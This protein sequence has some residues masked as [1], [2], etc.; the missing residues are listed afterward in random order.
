MHRHALG[1]PVRPAEADAW[2]GHHAAALLA[3][4]LPALVAFNLPPSATFLNQ[5]VALVGW[6]VWLAL[7]ATHGLLG[8]WRIG[9]GLASL[10]A[11]L[12]LVG[13]AA[14]VSW[15]QHLPGPLA[16]SAIG[17]IVA[18]AGIA[19]VAAMLARAEIADRLFRAFCVA[20]VVGGLLSVLI[21]V[22]QMFFPQLTVGGLISATS[23]E[24][25][26]VGNLRQ[27]NHLSS[28]LLW[29]LIA[30]V[31]LGERGTLPRAAVMAIVAVLVFG[32][33]MSASRTGV[34][35]I[36]LLVLWGLIDRRLSRTARWTLVLSPLLYWLF[37]WGL[38]Q[39]AQETRQV[40]GGAGRFNADGDISSSRF[41]IWRDTLDLVAMQPLW[42]V[43]FGEFN[44]AW[45]LTPFPQ[46]P[47]AFFDHTHNLPLQLLVEL[48][49]PLAGLVL[50]ALLYAL[51]RGFVAAWRAP[52]PERGLV[53]A[54]LLMV[55][56]VAVHS[57]FEYPLWYAYF[58]L[59]TAFLF[60]LCLGADRRAGAAPDGAARPIARWPVQLAAALLLVGG[61]AAIAD[62]RRVAAI[63]ESD[64]AMPLAERIERGKRSWFFAH[65]A[66]YAAATIAEHPSSEMPSFAVATH[67]LLDTRLMIA[68]A[69]ALNEA[70]D[71]E[72][73][74]H[75]AQRLRE[76]RNAD[77]RTFFAPCD[78]PRADAEPLPFQ[79]T[80]PTRAFGYRDFLR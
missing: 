1:A 52:D 37:W 77:A 43:G 63:F 41:A 75:L 12:G 7:I 24:G 30:A 34:A 19:G 55:M 70:G 18:A 16:A 47:V 50:L 3:V 68:W 8:P 58:L 38:G 35:G 6:G 2:P 49:W 33:V 17:L 13:G 79:C 67:Y 73:A 78:E 61:V 39:W 15:T 72:R 57:Q 5:A 53:R 51:V 59:P 48:G 65:H 71:V 31:W 36:V 27:A 74:R 28:L 80:P 69:T 45:S 26:A 60:G 32:V 64:D 4:A 14:V 66:H 22:L 20:L 21:G 76:F 10:L 54:A 42:G 62:Y 40:F 23:V 11:G 29:S 9:Q 44:F 56:M 46:R 25:R